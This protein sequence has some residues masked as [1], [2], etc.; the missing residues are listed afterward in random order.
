[1]QPIFLEIPPEIAA[2]I[3]L[4]PKRAQ[5][6]LMEEF[7]L[8]LYGE[9]II[10]GGQGAYLLKIDRLSFERFLAGHQIAIHCDV[11]ELDQDISQ[12]DQVL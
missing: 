6:V 5:R 4:P 11:E 9:G 12:L 8:R 3:K 2:Q 10:S 1:M 7:V